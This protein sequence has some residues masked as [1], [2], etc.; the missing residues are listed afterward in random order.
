MQ[1]ED[2]EEDFA[3]LRD[4]FAA[5]RNTIQNEL[6]SSRVPE[7]A[8]AMPAVYPGA[9]PPAANDEAIGGQFMYYRDKL[10]ASSAD[11]NQGAPATAR[12]AP[13]SV[14]QPLP[15]GLSSSTMRASPAAP[16]AP[17]AASV[18]RT[19]EDTVMLNAPKP[20][21]G[22]EPSLLAAADILRKPDKPARG[23][24]AANEAS[25]QPAATATVFAEAPRSALAD[26][27]AYGLGYAAD[28]EQF[29]PTSACAG[30][31]HPPAQ[32]Y[33]GLKL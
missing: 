15:A 14:R 19:A 23:D 3:S 16:P 10:S 31:N 13:N 8:M 25:A 11:R 20:G 17:E 4:Q 18:A 28:G 2:H 29:C 21:R 33:T 9:A 1:D 22:G 27:A 7:A 5:L 32:A 30:P 26:A 24:V 12:I 6:A